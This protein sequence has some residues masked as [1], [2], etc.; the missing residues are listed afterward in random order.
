MD[1]I[2]KDLTWKRSI[3]REY[4]SIED[5]LELYQDEALLAPHDERIRNLLGLAVLTGE[6]RYLDTLRREIRIRRHSRGQS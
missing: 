6:Q 3:S 2:G 5:A 1:L 4:M